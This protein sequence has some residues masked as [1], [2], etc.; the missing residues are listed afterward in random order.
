MVHYSP[1]QLLPLAQRTGRWV[2]KT[3]KDK[4]VLYTTNLGSS[5][6]FEC[7]QSQ[8][9]IIRV[10]NN[11]Q[12][13]FPSQMYAWRVDSGEWH[14]FAA[15]NGSCKITFTNTS[16]HLVE[17][18]T[19]GN[20]DMDQVWSGNQGFAL[21]GIDTTAGQLLPAPPR[22]LV[23][24]I[25]DSITA[26]C[27]VY[28]KQAALD[29]RPESNYVGLACDRLGID[30]VRIA[31]SA[32]GVLRPG[33][34]GVPVAAKF[35]KH[36]DATTEWQANHP[37]LV[38]VNLGVNDRRFTTAEFFPA[39]NEF[40]NQVTTTFPK[41]Q[42]LLLVPFSQTYREEIAKVANIHRVEVIDTTGWCTSY[43]DGLH[44]DQQGARTAAR[45]LA[46]ALSDKLRRI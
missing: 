20:T 10:L 28:G 1:R 13:G 17:I 42:V 11:G 8:Q 26:G 36:I 31:Y 30:G 5:I 24:F 15:S 25:G 6:R 40:I 33:T 22:P 43:T 14:R 38:V 2:I 44:P 12:P 32:A 4:P 23:D 18:T 46:Q 41:S 39:Y 27:W 9:L 21:A 16:R 7:E 45:Q 35:L 29:Y 37:Q 19:A 3:I 34:G